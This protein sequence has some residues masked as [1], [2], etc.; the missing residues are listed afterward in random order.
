MLVWDCGCSGRGS[1]V[2]DPQPQGRVAV[3]RPRTPHGSLRKLGTGHD[4]SEPAVFQA[5]GV[6]GACLNPFPI[7]RLEAGSPSG[8][9]AWKLKYLT[10]RSK[11]R[12]VQTP[13]GRPSTSPVRKPVN[14]KPKE[15]PARR[16]H[17]TSRPAA[18]AGP[19][20]QKSPSRRPAGALLQRNGGSPV[21]GARESVTHA[22]NVFEQLECIGPASMQGPATRTFPPDHSDG[23]AACR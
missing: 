4:S 16:R 17:L 1:L 22:V 7:H 23:A 14:W 13:C 18:A 2:D 9:A 15:E 21:L 10:R 12:S 6:G 8:K 20:T 3:T 11:P 5:G 19:M